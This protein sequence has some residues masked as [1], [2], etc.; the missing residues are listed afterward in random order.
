MLGHF[1][2]FIH[3]TNPKID[4]F[5]KRFVRDFLHYQD[6]IF[7]A[8]GKIV[9]ALQKESKERGFKLDLEGGGGYSSLHVRRGDFQFKE[10]W[11]TGK[12]LH[13]NTIELFHPHEILYVAT[14]ERN[15]TFFDPMKDHYELKDHHALRFLDNYTEGKGSLGSC[16]MSIKLV[17]I[18]LYVLLSN[19]IGRYKSEVLRNDRFNSGKSW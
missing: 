12:E 3:F 13:D 9:N 1:Y 19:R 14:D 15:K 5:Y 10:S 6:S 2:G 16:H 7:C 8:A 11:V 17:Y 4:N 18:T